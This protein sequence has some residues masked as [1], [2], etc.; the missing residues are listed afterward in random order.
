MTNYVS[1]FSSACIR[2]L[3]R[4]L[5]MLESTKSAFSMLS[6]GNQACCAYVFIKY[7][8]SLFFSHRC[9]HPHAKRKPPLLR[10]PWELS[11]WMNELWQ[12]YSLS[13]HH[14]WVNCSWTCFSVVCGTSMFDWLEHCIS[15]SYFLRSLGIYSSLCLVVCC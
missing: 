4:K 2:F 14:A 8:V 7:S 6:K 9:I 1:C 13:Y 15:Q 3:L 12:K 5:T 11:T 10:Q